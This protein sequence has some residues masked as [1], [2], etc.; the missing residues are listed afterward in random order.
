ML[1]IIADTEQISIFNY[2]INKRFNFCLDAK[3][4][5]I[6]NIIHT[7]DGLD[8]VHTKTLKLNNKQVQILSKYAQYY[9]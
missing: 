3:A 8:F 2:T 9:M 7:N 4:L 5:D 1:D 6:F